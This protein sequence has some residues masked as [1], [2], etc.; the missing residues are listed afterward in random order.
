[1]RCLPNYMKHFLKKPISNRAR[2]KLNISHLVV[3]YLLNALIL[4]D[5][6]QQFI[7]LLQRCLERT[8]QS[9]VLYDSYG[10]LHQY[11]SVL[12][13]VLGSSDTDTLSVW[14]QCSLSRHKFS[15]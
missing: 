15:V 1:M 11:R 8:T 2:T 5:L 6:A 10:V 14:R 9:G 12:T 13:G 3:L 4:L 7:L